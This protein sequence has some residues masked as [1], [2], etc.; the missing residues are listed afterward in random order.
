VGGVAG[1]IVWPLALADLAA[2]AVSDAQGQVAAGLDPRVPIALAMLLFAAVAAALERRAS[3]TFGFLDL[4]GDLSIGSAA[5]VAVVGAA[6]GASA[7]MGPAFA[8]LIVGSVLFGAAGLSGKRRP[9][10][11]S[12]LV[13]AGA[14]GLL[15]SYL[16]AAAV[17]VGQVADV[18]PTVLLSLLLHAAGWAWLGVHLAVGRSR[19][20]AAGPGAS[21]DGAADSD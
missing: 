7:L 2:R 18:A 6:F 19:G 8:L 9:Q 14:G 15:A 17:G 1:A 16:V 10:W 12:A 20:R 11:G 5:I 21:P 3:T 4:V 13:A